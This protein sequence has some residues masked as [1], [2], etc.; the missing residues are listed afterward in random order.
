MNLRERRQAY[1]QAARLIENGDAAYCCSALNAVGLGCKEFEKWFREDL[2]KDAA[3]H[4]YGAEEAVAWM[5]LVIH[6]EK[7][8]VDTHAFR[9]TALCFMAE[10]CE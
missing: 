2:I 9:I 7:D 10:V 1:K 3:P 8:G 4:Y 5:T 6:S